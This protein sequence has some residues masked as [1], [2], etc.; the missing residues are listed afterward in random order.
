MSSRLKVN[1]KAPEFVAATVDGHT[2]SLS[3]VYK[4][5][6]VVLIFLRGFF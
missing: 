3:S 2:F 5:G 4:D 6:P 1:M